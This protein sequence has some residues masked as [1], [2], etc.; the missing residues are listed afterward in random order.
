MSFFLTTSGKNCSVLDKLDYVWAP[1]ITYNLMVR[2]KPLPRSLFRCFAHERTSSWSEFL[3]WG[4]YSFNTGY[5]TSS[6]TTPFKYV[7]GRDPSPLNPYVQG[8]VAYELALPANSK[9]HP[10]FYVSLLRLALGQAVSQPPTPLPI[11]ADWEQILVSDKI[12]THRWIPRSNNLELM[13]QWQHQPLE[14][15]T[16]EDYDFLAHQYPQFCLEDKASFQGKY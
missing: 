2:T 13:V 9:S 6:E 10:I 8:L 14:E 16:W 12:L 3:D 1:L 4:E 7:Y 11:T 5:H 15:S